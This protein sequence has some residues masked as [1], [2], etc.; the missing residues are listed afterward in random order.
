M[1]QG[2][3]EGGQVAS[4]QQQQVTL[5]N[6]TSCRMAN[7]V[8]WPC[9]YFSAMDLLLL[10]GRTYPPNVLEL[11]R[12]AGWTLR[13]V[14]PIDPPHPSDF[15]RFRDQF[16]KLHLWTMEEYAE[17]CHAAILYSHVTWLEQAQHMHSN[18]SNSW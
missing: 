17:V 5:C 16:V 15:A 2:E 18:H 12:Q 3:G 14:Q 7:I 10:S 11:A 13:W 8:S 1:L 4:Q 9:R 6:M